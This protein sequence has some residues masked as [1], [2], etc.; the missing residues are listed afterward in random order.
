[1]ISKQVFTDSKSTGAARQ[2]KDGDPLPLSKISIGLQTSTRAK[3]IA[4]LNVSLANAAVLSVKTK[5]VHWDV[6]GPQFRSL[7]RLLDENYTAIEAMIDALAERARMLGG[8]TIG[9]MA[10]FVRHSELFES[11]Q[12]YC[13]ST[14]A[15]HLLV[16]DH[17][18]VVRQVRKAVSAC[19]ELDD[20]GTADMLT[21]MLREH[22]QMLWML[23][24]FV[25]GESVIPAGD[26]QP[27]LAAAA[28]SQRA[29]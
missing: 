2:A 18:T 11:D 10:D 27:L 13:H 8:H 28:S 26:H 12:I 14:A 25:E 21:G 15:V 6:V 1:M 22:E 23:R 4:Q 20:A 16:T 19:A 9:T 5:K 24:S 17:E 7:H 3:I 29:D